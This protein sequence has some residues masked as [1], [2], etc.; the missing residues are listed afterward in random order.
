MVMRR[1]AWAAGAWLT[2]VLATPVLATPVLATPVLAA[3]TLGG[4]SRGGG[5]AAAAVPVVVI[6]GK[7]F[8]HG[9]GMAQDGAYWMGRAGASSSQILEQFYPGTTRATMSGEV[10]VEVGGG[11]GAVLSFPEGGQVT[12]GPSVLAVPPGGQVVLSDIGGRYLAQASY[13]A[14][15][16]GG[17]DA[18]PTLEPAVGRAGPAGTRSSTD[19]S[20]G[21]LGLFCPPPSSPATT[22]TTR[23]PPGTGPGPTPG[24]GTVPGPGPTGPGPTG[25]GPTGPGVTPAPGHG[26]TTTTTTPGPPST[27]SASPLLATAA[28]GGTIGVGGRRYRGSIQLVGGTLVN[29]LDVEDY[30]RGMGEVLDA[31]WPAASLQA[32]AI[33]E[34]TYA[35]RAMQASGQICAD[36]RCQVYLGA[37]VEYPAMDQAV[38]ATRGQVLRYGGSLASTVFSA[39]GGGYEATPQEGFGGSN[40]GYP[41]LRAAPYLTRDPGPWSV[42]VGLSAL[43]SQLGYHGTLSDVTVS[44]KGPSGRALAVSL[45]GTAGTQVVPGLSFASSLNLRSTLFTTQVSAAATAPGLPPPGPPLQGLPGAASTVAPLTGS[46]TPPAGVDPNLV[47]S[48][49]HAALALPRVPTKRRHGTTLATLAALAVLSGAA[50]VALAK[51]G[52]AS[53]LGRPLMATGQGAVGLAVSLAGGATGL[54]ARVKGRTAGETLSP[55]GLGQPGPGGGGTGIGRLRAGWRAQPLR[56]D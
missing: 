14:G 15:S 38:A 25:P 5:A 19:A 51:L 47:G 27:A 18:A 56:R 44:Q 11:S 37:Q 24:A 21:L 1:I 9:V 3:P 31:S 41:Y 16:G 34:R 48:S 32:Q 43:A 33:A 17:P 46:A 28:N 49:P 20:C 40:A 12:G 10:R 52:P 26:T 36:T 29:Q 50:T 42:S 13:A 6:N 35:L 54:V 4:P 45:T 22:T 55:A 2:V 23:P 53:R 39:N 8:G 7:G 30:L